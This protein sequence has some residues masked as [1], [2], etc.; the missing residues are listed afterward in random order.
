[1]SDSTP[2]APDP[3]PQPWEIRPRDGSPAVR[4][5]L[6]LPAEA[7]PG[8]AVVICHG[9][10]G[11]KDWG[12]FPHLASSLA[13]RGHAAISFNFSHSG[14]GA[15]GVDFSALELF[16]RNTHTRNLEEIQWVLDALTEGRLLRQPPLRI[17]LVGHSRG[18]GEAVLVTAEDERVT[19]LVTWNA[20]ASVER[21]QEA[22]IAAWERG[23]T[24]YIPNARTGQQMP[25]E[26]VYWRNLQLH[27][28]RLDI[29]RAA[30][31][32][33]VPWLIVHG[34]ADETVSVDDA[35]RLH[36][37]AGDRAELALI[38]DAGHTFGAT[39]PFAGVTPELRLAVEA[40]QRWFDTYLSGVERPAATGS[41]PAGGGAIVE[42]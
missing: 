38:A 35:R 41:N 26:P 27:R 40:T 21:W 23:E 31:R 39:H 42:P 36:R 22:Q 6:R 16:A 13:E 9:F 30:E 3:T 37:A 24:V 4:G 7:D 25:L 18:G 1:M 5:E 12:F 8:T 19:A 2:S 11:F 28:E 20:I 32:V 33:A 14:V 15:D 34:E 17:G 29:L 10:K